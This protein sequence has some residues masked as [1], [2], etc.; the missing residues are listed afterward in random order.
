MR[1]ALLFVACIFAAPGC[2]DEGS[3]EP[4]P[5]DEIPRTEWSLE[6]RIEE[7]Q[8]LFRR[9]QCSNCHKTRG[10]LPMVGPSLF[11]VG[12][13]LDRQALRNWVFD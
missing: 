11:D 6:R 13:R 9:R 5:Q 12:E 4:S 2:S 7:G 10:T 1:R 3:E 8:S